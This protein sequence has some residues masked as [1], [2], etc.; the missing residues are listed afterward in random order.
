[1]FECIDAFALCSLIPKF[2]TPHTLM[3]STPLLITFTFSVIFFILNH[4]VF[5]WDEFPTTYILVCRSQLL[6][7]TSGWIYAMMTYGFRI[8]FLKSQYLVTWGVYFVIIVKGSL[9]ATQLT[10]LYTVLCMPMMSG[11]NHSNIKVH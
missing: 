11:W 1:M 10:P 8:L 5:Y 3:A 9:S 6:I 4:K 2:R 7:H